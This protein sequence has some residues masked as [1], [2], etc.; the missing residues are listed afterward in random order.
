MENYIRKSNQLLSLISGLFKL[1]GLGIIVL[2]LWAY[3]AYLNKAHGQVFQHVYALQSEV[4]QDSQVI[5][6]T[7]LSFVVDRDT[8][9]IRELYMYEGFENDSR[10]DGM[11]FIVESDTIQADSG[12][13][14]LFTTQIPKG[15]K[16]IWYLNNQIYACFR[17]QVKQR[18]SYKRQ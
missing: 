2:I 18:P 16:A 8:Q 9:V 6:A 11:R 7:T 14:Y 13:V 17:P 5:N 1:I 12:N 10:H 3:S 15:F 4:V